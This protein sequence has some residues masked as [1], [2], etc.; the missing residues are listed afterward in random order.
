MERGA[1]QHLS[2]IRGVEIESDAKTNETLCQEEVQWF[3]INAR[4]ARDTT[5][6]W[7]MAIAQF[8]FL[9]DTKEVRTTPMESNIRVIIIIRSTL[10]TLGRLL[11]TQRPAQQLKLA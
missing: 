6:L 11:L 3:L 1:N 7:D 10:L 5:A 9:G 2:I 4:E 8:L